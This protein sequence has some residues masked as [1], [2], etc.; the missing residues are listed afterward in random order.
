MGVALVAVSV[1]LGARLFAAAD[2]TVAVWAA[3]GDL[4]AGTPVRAADLVPSQVRFSSSDEADR[5][6]SAE[7]PV[8]EGAAL[9]RPVGAGELLPRAALGG[10]TP[11]ALVEVPLAVG[12]AALPATV[13]VGSVV[14]VWVTPDSTGQ[15]GGEPG[16]PTGRTGPAGT[17]SAGARLVLDSVP[18]LGVPQA[19]GGL[20]PV[21][22][23]QVIVGVP[24]AE[25]TRLAEALAAVAGGDVVVTRRG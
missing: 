24:A 18:V 15:T 13:R 11:A 19:G 10:R 6:L 5:Y 17:T 2:D 8:P 23:R 21:T 3:R 12:E 14:D 4:A 25:R 22:V 1:L 20:G 9:A 16:G 7:Q